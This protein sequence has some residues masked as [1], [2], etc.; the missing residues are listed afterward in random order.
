MQVLYKTIT[1]DTQVAVGKCYL[2]GVEFTHTDAAE[3]R[4]YDEAD[5]DKTATQ[6]IATLRVTATAQDASKMFEHPIKCD[7]IFVDYITNGLGTVYYHY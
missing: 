5:S 2:D 1:T 7:G 3:M 4:V 6:R